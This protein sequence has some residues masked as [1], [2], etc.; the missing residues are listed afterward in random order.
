MFLVTHVGK[1]GGSSFREVVLQL[2]G[3]NRVLIDHSPRWLFRNGHKRIPDETKLP[4]I[5]LP[6]IQKRRFEC[7]FGHEAK[8]EK[9]S[10]FFED[11]IAVT[12][13]RDPV[14]RLLSQYYY[15]ARIENWKYKD[16]PPNVCHLLEYAE[17]FPNLQVEYWLP[18]TVIDNYQFV[19]LVEHYSE[20]VD[21]FLHKYGNGHRANV[22]RL[23]VNPTLPTY[24]V[25]KRLRRR[26]EKINERGMEL[27]A[28]VKDKWR[29]GEY[30][31]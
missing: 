10:P 1:A 27:Y 25:S 20:H 26:L 15:E 31:D 14:N 4:R 30:E 9:W 21:I 17:R 3:K 12:W 11:L 6:R 8:Y 7:I 13:I 16:W 29:N 24:P 19:G 5:W 22:P 23:N 28:R 2:F 18:L